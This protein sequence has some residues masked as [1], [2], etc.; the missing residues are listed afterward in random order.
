MSSSICFF[1]LLLGESWV[2]PRHVYN[3]ISLEGQGCKQVYVAH[4]EHTCDHCRFCLGL[5]LP[6]SEKTVPD[7]NN[8][9]PATRAKLEISSHYFLLVHLDSTDY[10][11]MHIHICMCVD[12]YIYTAWILIVRK[13]SY[14][15]AT[16]SRLDG[17]SDGKKIP[18][19]Y[20]KN[21]KFRC[22]SINGLWVG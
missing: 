7:A 12:I 9:Q 13:T 21:W 16:A 4:G 8:W 17:I 6:T 22:P 19:R 10:I 2:L 14:V 20:G 15:A 5:T 1:M 11:L 3:S 18:K